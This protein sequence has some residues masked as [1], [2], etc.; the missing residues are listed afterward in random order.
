MVHMC[1][2]VPQMLTTTG[3]IKSRE[4]APLKRSFWDNRKGVMIGYLLILFLDTLFTAVS[5]EFNLTIST[6]QTNITSP[7]YNNYGNCTWFLQTDI[8]GYKIKIIFHS[9]NLQFNRDFL[10][11]RNIFSRYGKDVCSVCAVTCSDRFWP[12]ALLLQS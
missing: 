1:T 6:L 3:F 11:V 10:T 2:T 4:Q 9:L 5:C 8:P 12:I 7:A